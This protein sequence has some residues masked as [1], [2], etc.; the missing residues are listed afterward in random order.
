MAL[1][2]HLQIKFYQNTTLLHIC[3]LSAAFF[4]PEQQLGRFAKFLSYLNAKL[5]NYELWP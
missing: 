3:I 2:L 5:L 4:V 1:A